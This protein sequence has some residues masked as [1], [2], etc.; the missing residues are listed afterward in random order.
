[1][2]YVNTFSLSCSPGIC[3]RIIWIFLRWFQLT[4][5]LLESII[6]KFHISCNP[7]V[8]SSYFKTFPLLSWTY[9][10]W[11]FHVYE[12]T[13]Y[14]LLTPIVI[15]GLMV[16]IFLWAFMFLYHNVVTFVSWLFFYQFCYMFIPVFIFSFYS[17]F[18][19]HGEVQF[20]TLCIMSLYTSKSV[21]ICFIIII[22]IVIIIEPAY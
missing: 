1:M 7:T 2:A 6:F 14:F 5:L 20:T 8:T 15:S 13:S 16:R 21:N 12:R 17:H 11:N 4:L 19:A 22:I 10:S 3:S 18:L 9:V